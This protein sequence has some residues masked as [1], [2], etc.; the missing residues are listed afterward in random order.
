M[1]THVRAFLNAPRPTQPPHPRTHPPTFLFQ[2]TH[3]HTHHTPQEFPGA[4]RIVS[5]LETGEVS[6]R[7][8][9]QHRIVQDD[10]INMTVTDSGVFWSKGGGF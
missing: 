3:T 6:V 8:L 10:R 7:E 5:D 4:E 1:H 9:Q 2:Q